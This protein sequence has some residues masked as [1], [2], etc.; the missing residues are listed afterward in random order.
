[1]K[2]ER[3]R[4]PKSIKTH[5]PCPSL[6]SWLKSRRPCDFGQAE[7]YY[8]LSQKP[9]KQIDRTPRD[10][11]IYQESHV[12]HRQKHPATIA[13]LAPSRNHDPF[14]EYHTEIHSAN[15]ASDLESAPRN[16]ERRY[17]EASVA[18][19]YHRT[20]TVAPG[21][22]WPSRRSLPNEMKLSCPASIRSKSLDLQTDRH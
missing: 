18:G 7:P 2:N 13:L 4:K 1:M 16:T 20:G 11:I 3:K 22:P 14:V 9:I 19:M 17:R 10:D 6:S 12:R 5:S 8:S 21:T 15:G